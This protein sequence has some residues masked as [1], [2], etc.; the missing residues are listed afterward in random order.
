MSWL[1]NTVSKQSVKLAVS[2]SD[3]E[4]ELS[5]ASTDV[6]QEVARLLS[7]P[8]SVRIS[9]DAQEVDEAGGVLDDEEH[10]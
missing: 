8:G 7:N 1:V 3:Q 4:D 2:I 6:H 5:S 10:M 9:R